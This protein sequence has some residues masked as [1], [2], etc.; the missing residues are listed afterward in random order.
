MLACHLIISSI[1]LSVIFPSPSHSRPTSRL[2]SSFVHSPPSFIRS[3]IKRW[4]GP[5]DAILNQHRFNTNHMPVGCRDVGCGLINIHQSG[6]RKR[7]Y[8]GEVDEERFEQ[9][10]EIQEALEDYLRS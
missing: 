5:G 8:D 7:S 2:S 10:M 6:K 4:G 9:L 1:L 3:R